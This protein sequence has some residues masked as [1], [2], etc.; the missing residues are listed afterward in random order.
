MPSL[1]MPK[2]RLWLSARGFLQVETSGSSLGWTC[3]RP[4]CSAMATSLLM[5]VGPYCSLCWFN[6]A[7]VLPAAHQRLLRHARHT[8]VCQPVVCRSHSEST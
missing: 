3:N 5:E 4:T 2:R 1:L 8:A 6:T 7:C